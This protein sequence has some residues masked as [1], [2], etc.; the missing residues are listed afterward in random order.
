MEILRQHQ[1]A[2]RRDLRRRRRRRPGL[3]H[4]R[5]HQ[6]GAAGDPRRRRADERLRR[7]AAIDRAGRRVELADVGLFS[8]GTAVKHGR[9]RDVSPRA[10][11]RRRM[12]RRRHRRRL[13][14]HQGR[15]RG[16]P[17]HP[18]AGGRARRR[19]DQA[20]RRT[21]HADQRRD[22]RRDHLRRQHELRSAALRR[23]ARRGGR[24][25][26][27]DVRGHDPGGA[28]QLPPLLRADRAARGHRVQLPHRRRRTAPTSSS[29]SP[30]STAPNRR[31]SPRE[32]EQPRLRHA[33][34]DRRRARQGA[35]APHGRRAQR[36]WRATSGSTASCS[37]SGRAR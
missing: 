1:G 19:R 30:P 23:R 17:Q 14:R 37:R 12:D 6:G 13:R 2:D 25:A 31:C 21:T 26:R 11:A 18:R 27:G 16:H 29:A 35:R 3:G 8:D 36:R 34:P 10:R 4:R 15:L 5:L 22:L 32:F 20:V 24:G 33:R 28:R 7:D 9:R